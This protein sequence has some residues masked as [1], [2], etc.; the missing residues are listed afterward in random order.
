[1]LILAGVSLNAV[2]G[3]NGIIT[4]AQN[5]S[6]A[7]SVA[8]LQDF[9]DNYYVEHYDEFETSSNKV[10]AIR[11]KNINWFYYTSEGY[12]TDSEGHAL[13]LIVKSELEKDN[14]DLDLLGG[15]AGE[16]TYRD[17]A[18][19][20]DVYGVTT[21]LKVYYCPQGSDSIIGINKDD[22]DN[23]DYGRVV[24]DSS[25]KL[26]QLITGGTDK[27]LTASEVR[28][29][30]E[31]TIDRDSGLTDLSE[32]YKL[33]SLEELTIK[34]LKDTE[35]KLDGIENVLKLKYICFYN[36]NL[37]DYSKMQSLT[38]LEYL[39]LYNSNNEEV[40]KI[41]TSMQNKDY[42]KL[43]YLGIFGVSL[44]NLSTI[45]NDSRESTNVTDISPLNSLSQNTKNSVSYLIL[46][47]NNISS[48]NGISA[49]TNLSTLRIEGNTIEGIAECRDMNNLAFL[50]MQNNK[51]ESL[52]GLE[53][54]KKLETLCAY[55][56]NLTNIEAIANNTI[57]EYLHLANNTNLQN[58]ATIKTNTAL[59]TLYLAGC[60]NMIADEV[61]EIRY[62]YNAISNYWKSIPEK[63]L[64][65]L[66][67]DDKID[68]NNKN[69]SD[70]QLATL[71][72]STEVT[73]LRL[74][75]NSN[76]G[77]T[78][79]SSLDIE[80]QN[81]IKDRLG[82]NATS[83]DAYLRY[84]LSTLTNMQY[85]S[86]EGVTN[87]SSLDFIKYMPNL[88]ELD[89]RNTNI[90]D[91]SILEDLTNENQLQQFGVLAINN[92]AIDLTKIQNTISNLYSRKSG[93]WSTIH[94]YE[95]GGLKIGNSTLMKSLENCTQITKLKLEMLITL[96][97]EI[98]DFSNC[99]NLTQYNGVYIASVIKLPNT[100]TSVLGEHSQF[101]IFEDNSTISS[102][103]I[104]NCSETTQEGFENMLN[105]LSTCTTLRNFSTN[106]I[107]NV[108]SLEGISNLKNCNLNS[109]YIYP[110][111]EILEDISDLEN[112]YSSN[113]S[114]NTIQIETG[115]I[116][117]LPDLS[118]LNVTNLKLIDMQLENIDG[119]RNNKTIKNLNLKN[120]KIQ[121]IES[122]ENLT[123][124]T[125]LNLSNNSI[126]NS[127][128]DSINLKKVNNISILYNLNHSV[129]S[130]NNLVK[131]DLSN[132]NLEE[133]DELTKLKSLSWEYSNW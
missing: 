16:G 118:N 34:N 98:F 5:A 44:S 92:V 36:C 52:T 109:I 82:E 30:K 33:T 99:R 22:L 41:C 115:N 42:T 35:I 19:L 111:Y 90:T 102:L 54:C 61:R 51:V 18:N 47:N 89:I 114:I 23:E 72:N 96:K 15:D 73:K 3:D 130:S 49:F 10:E 93:F 8:K 24:I 125:E 103:N 80:T 31:L 46:N 126:Y 128:Y 94:D 29:V 84:V 77:N 68:Y 25:S 21:D 116:K 6:Y 39:Y 43:K 56:N 127:Y 60:E 71:V 37:A 112:L 38:D 108:T 14:P 131:I 55:N 132:N 4:Q 32:L 87:L 133:T 53:N 28:N 75:N 113:C 1:M 13:Y 40:Q 129:N 106:N 48:L 7:Q 110:R 58:V 9:L 86:L 97:N 95:R 123:T 81:K 65:Y 2:I 62:V 124:L 66:N 45:T 117:E 101:P 11:Q 91:L 121:N 122:L 85:L 67:T 64:E 26:A 20:N 104:N 76:L 119:L 12:L 78:N 120:N 79:F 59:D 17:Y 27:G 83:N 57:L 88:I 63:Y 70:S 74:R 105:S 107:Y 69:Y 100:V 50:T